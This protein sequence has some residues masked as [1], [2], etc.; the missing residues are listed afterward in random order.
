MSYYYS[1]FLAI[2][3][4]SWCMLYFTDCFQTKQRSRVQTNSSSFRWL[5]HVQVLCNIIIHESCFDVKMPYFHVP[6][7]C[8]CNQCSECNLPDYWCSTASH[9]EHDILAIITGI[10]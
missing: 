3:H 1:M 2:T 9:S 8:Y 6:C 10:G 7:S 4:L 5:C